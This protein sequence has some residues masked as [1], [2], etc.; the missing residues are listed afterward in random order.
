MVSGTISPSY[1]EYFSPFPHGTSSLSVSWEYLALADGAA[2]FRQDSSGPALLR[3]TLQLVNLPVRDY[4]SLWWIFPHPSSLFTS[5]ISRSYNPR[6]AVT[7]L[8][9]ALARSLA[10]T[11]AIII[12]FLFLRLLRCFSSAGSPSLRNTSSS[13]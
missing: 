11:C 6:S 8:V 10:T 3:N 4:H 1:S 7:D 13:N 2:R 9:W 5:P 12:Y